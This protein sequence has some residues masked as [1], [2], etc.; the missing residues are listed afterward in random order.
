MACLCIMIES[1]RT[2]VIWLTTLERCRRTFWER[3]QSGWW[4]DAR[5]V[6][7]WTVNYY[8]P[9]TAW[10]CSSLELVSYFAHFL[11]RSFDWM[12]ALRRACGVCCRRVCHACKYAQCALYY[13]TNTGTQG[14]ELWGT[15]Q[16]MHIWKKQVHVHSVRGHD[17]RAGS[18]HS[19]ARVT[20]LHLELVEAITL[21]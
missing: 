6:Y 1:R 18:D 15:Y 19:R 5:R 13:I 8:W 14:T 12:A 4:N 3:L 20:T 7:Y 17:S 10:L 21:C 16:Y 9:T 2:C 11:N